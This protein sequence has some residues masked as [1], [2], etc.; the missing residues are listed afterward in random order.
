MH[1]HGREIL[2]G[3]AQAGLLKNDWLYQNYSFGSDE[4]VAY[5]S[6]AEIC[7]GSPLAVSYVHLAME[8][9]MLS[10]LPNLFDV[11]CGSGQEAWCF[12]RSMAGYVSFTQMP[13]V[14]PW[15]AI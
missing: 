15:S 9:A 13:S 7:L 1:E 12:E 3:Q 11:Y 6:G 2:T 4:T 5:A 14:L 8:T 10:L